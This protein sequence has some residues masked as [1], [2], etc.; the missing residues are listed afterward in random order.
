M[1]TWE[2]GGEEFKARNTEK[3]ITST[4]LSLSES[5]QI[6]SNG[7]FFVQSRVTKS[8]QES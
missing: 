7:E 3:E 5:A 6:T 8:R 4:I 1:Y 2:I